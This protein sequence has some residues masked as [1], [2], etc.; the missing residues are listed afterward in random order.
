MLQYLL[1]CD[2]QPAQS[3]NAEQTWR[4]KPTVNTIGRAPDCDV[5]V[6]DPDKSVSRLQLELEPM[7]QGVRA[8]QKGVNGSLINGEELQLHQVAW[9]QVGD[10]LQVGPCTWVLQADTEGSS[11][12]PDD[13]NPFDEPQPV[14]HNTP[15]T[16]NG[17]A[18]ESAEVWLRA[19][20][21]ADFLALFESETLQAPQA[22]ASKPEDQLHHR[23]AAHWSVPARQP[24]ASAVDPHSAPP[25]DSL[26]LQQGLE[27]HWSAFAQGLGLQLANSSP[28]VAHTLG[29]ALR[30]AL[31]GYLNLL[32]ARM[33]FK[34]EVHAEHT[35]LMPRDNNPLKFCPSLEELL[36]RVVRTGANSYMT[37]DSAVSEAAAD[38][39]VHQQVS[40]KALK[41]SLIELSRSL[42]PS[43][44]ESESFG[45]NKPWHMPSAQWRWQQFCKA[46]AERFETS[47][48][49]FG[50]L[51]SSVYRQAYE[52]LS[53]RGSAS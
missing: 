16:L 30:A 36:A 28:E 35:T 21:Q 18:D 2:G 53:K 4:L 6:E 38:L 17:D 24:Y 23:H 9:L 45:H 8:L 7:P 25:A 14:G 20:H 22:T 13:W 49:P 41:L 12:I 1:V 34:N 19:P 3:A 50:P 15:N 31:Q 10:R 29:L 37:L 5:V 48:D 47:A 40:A 44:F 32:A 51:L 11:N 33:H 43:Q 26:A 46:Y 27:S 42:H 39:V 52:S